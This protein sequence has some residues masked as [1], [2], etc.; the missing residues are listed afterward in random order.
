MAIK[1][2]LDVGRDEAADNNSSKGSSVGLYKPLPEGAGEKVTNELFIPLYK[3]SGWKLFNLSV[4]EAARL[5]AVT[6]NPLVNVEGKP[7]LYTFFFKVPMHSVRNFTRS[8]GSVG[9]AGV[10][11]PVHFN[12]YLVKNLGYKPLF[13]NPRCAFCEATAHAWSEHNDRWS[14]LEKEKGIVKKELNK[15]GYLNIRKN[16]PILSQSYEKASTFKIQERYITTVFDQGALSG[17][18][19]LSEG[20]E[21][22]YKIWFTPRTVVDTLK[23]LWLQSDRYGTPSF[24]EFEN[25]NGFQILSITKDTTECTSLSMRDT[26]YTVLNGPVVPQSD[27][28]KAYLT[29]LDGMPDPTDL[30]TLLPYEEMSIYAFPQDMSSLN[31]PVATTQQSVAPSSA[32]APQ[33][34]VS[35]TPA[36]PAPAPAPQA[37][38]APAMPPAAPAPPTATPPTS[39]APPV[40]G[41]PTAPP[42]MAAP[43][44]SPAPPEPST[45]VPVSPAFSAS[46]HAEADDGDDI[47]W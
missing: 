17:H 10:I 23:E 41:P 37:A 44:T 4:E 15:D 18:R 26:K 45:T 31:K 7:D 8:D 25:P 36:V 9:F 30:L 12:Q 20:E 3:P 39:P 11:C 21:L 24:F 13:N 33:A 43:P 29:N 19:R 2:T 28:W 1:M 46:S 40:A 42:P 5:N 16:D 14:L 22:A 38:P 27:E 6:E 34:P 47:D 32:P 35:T